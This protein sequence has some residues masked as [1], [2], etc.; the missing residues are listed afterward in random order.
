DFVYLSQVMQAEGIG[1]AATHLRAERPHS[2]G[3]LY[4]QL[5]DVWPGA[6]WASIDYF[7]RWKALQFHAK[8]FYAPQMISAL[9]LNGATE[10][11]LISDAVEP[12]AGQWRLRV[13]DTAGKVLQERGGAVTLQPLGGTPVGG[14]DDT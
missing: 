4:W 6:S 13:M 7:G 14:F 10:V 3:S 5:N 9:R 1:L 12:Q 8:R 11:K 2:M